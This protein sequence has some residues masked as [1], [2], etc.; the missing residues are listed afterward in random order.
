[1]KEITSRWVPHALTEE[2]CKERVRICKE[3]L[4][5]FKENKW[6]LV[7]VVTSDDSWFY[8]R[9]IGKKQLNKS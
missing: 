1:M 6:H 9:Q 2:N 5:K 7:D 3:N 8:L 4:A